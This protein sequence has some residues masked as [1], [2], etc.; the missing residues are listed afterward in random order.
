MEILLVTNNKH[1][2]EEIKNKITDIKFILLSDINFNEEIIENGKTFKE[3]AKI[4]CDALKKYY[5]GMILSDD[6]GLMVSS[7]NNLPGV[8]SKRFSS[9]CSDSDNR[10]KLLEMLE[11]K[12]N[13]NACFKTVLC[14]Y[15]NNQYFYFDGTLEGKITYF[16][17][18]NN[19]FG[20]DSIFIPKNK[21]KT[22]A[23]ISLEE[24]NEISHRSEALKKLEVFLNENSN[25]S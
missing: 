23:E 17:K 14:L 25:N 22:L 12:K 15:F 8:H 21:N 5:N 11:N 24:K 16:E 19:G 20:Y 10:K 1:K 2:L 3:N 13:R 4:K 6:S 9:S 7:L 18:G